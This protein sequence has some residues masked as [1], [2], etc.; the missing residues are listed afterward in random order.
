[1]KANKEHFPMSKSIFP[2][3]SQRSGFA[4]IRVQSA[5]PSPKTKGP[6]LISTLENGRGRVEFR[7]VVRGSGVRWRLVER[8]PAGK[9]R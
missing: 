2:P 1:M 9:C 5:G 8:I 3:N 6:F 4:Q 7:I